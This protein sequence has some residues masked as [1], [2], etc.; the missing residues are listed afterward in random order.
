MEFEPTGKPDFAKGKGS[1]GIV[2]LLVDGKEAARYP[3]L[4]PVNLQQLVY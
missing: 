2:K 1:P 4:S 3:T